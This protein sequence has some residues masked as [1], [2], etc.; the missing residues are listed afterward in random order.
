M[1]S[2]KIK[3]NILLGVHFQSHYMRFSSTDRFSQVKNHKIK[4]ND[5]NSQ[6]LHE[7]S[8]IS[9][10]T[11]W[12][13]AADMMRADKF[14]CTRSSLPI[15]NSIVTKAFTEANHTLGWELLNKIS[16]CQF[17]PDCESFIAYFDFCSLDKSTFPHNVEKMFEFIAKHEIIVSET[18]IEE[19]SHRI[20]HFGGS[21]VP[22]IVNID[23]VCEK[24]E[25]QLQRLQQSKLD[26]QNLKRE[27]E[28][29]LIKT[30]VSSIESGILR[31]MVNKKKTYDFV[32][33]ALNVT[34][35]FPEST[36]NILKQGK[37]L[38]Q[39]VEQLKNLNKKIF[40][41]GKKHVDEWPE[42]SI[43]FVRKNATVYLTN[44]SASVDDVLMMYAALLSGSKC[45]FITNDLLE[46][47]SYEFS[48]HGR[49]LFRNW[50]K[51]HQHFVSFNQQSDSIQLHRPKK[52][53]FN[54]SKDLGSG[55][56]HIPFTEKPLMNSLRGLIRIPIRWACVKLKMNK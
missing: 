25:Y 34:R 54:A 53:N 13:K 38:A 43:N 18:V 24:C 47:H 37:L 4:S 40:V 5:G 51:E 21:A 44:R 14:V 26:F 3:P 52:F 46:E 17:Q 49:I 48:K 27:F 28:E 45:H 16:D 35:V 2:I 39:F 42:Q 10:S 15:F 50:Q 36:G 1:F 33:D 29:V 6:F 9:K 41:V 11:N 20:Q 7:L 22:V 31:Q 56:W 19:I 8:E 23:G 32:I 12:T 30:K 55:Q